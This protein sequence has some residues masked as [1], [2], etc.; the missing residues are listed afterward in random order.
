MPREPDYT[1]AIVDANG[2]PDQTVAV[3]DG[4]S[5]LSPSAGDVLI[6]NGTRW[7]NTPAG[8]LVGADHGSLVGLGDD[9]HPQYETS[10]EAAAKVTAHEAAG[11]PHPTYAT[12]ADLTTHA[13]AADP[14]TGYQKESEKDAASGYMG[15]D[16]NSLGT[17]RAPAWNAYKQTGV[18]RENY[19]RDRVFAQ[20]TAL[21]AQRLYLF[22]IGLVAGD[23]IAGFRFRSGT[24]ALSGGAH[25]WCGLFDS[26]RVA[27]K[28]SAADDTGV[29]WGATAD[30]DFAL[31]SA[32]VIPTTDFYY[33]GLMIDAS[34]MPTMIGLTQFSSTVS[35]LAPITIIAADTGLTTLPNLPFTAGAGSAGVTWAWV[36]AL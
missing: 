4:I 36:R 29:T 1:V 9:D 32:Y 13:G 25:A 15:L 27:L 23:S 3:I 31:S 6:H 7:V 14:H 2:E 8:L 10:A 17:K 34:T 5:D 30:K 11:N 19:G 21:T 26:S 28:L 20:M 33:A 12:D 22:G 16:A 35:G 24:T 18:V